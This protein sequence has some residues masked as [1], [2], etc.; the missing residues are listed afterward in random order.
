MSRGA[1]FGGAGAF[2]FFAVLFFVATGFDVRRAGMG[3]LQPNANR[4]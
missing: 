3:R 2:G 1:A 4:D